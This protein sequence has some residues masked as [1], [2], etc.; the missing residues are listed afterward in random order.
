VFLYFL[1]FVFFVFVFAYLFIM[2]LINFLN[3]A[4]RNSV[5][6]KWASARTELVGKP[7][8]EEEREEEDLEVIEQ[9]K[10]VELE[11]WRTG[12]LKTGESDSNANFLPVAVDW[13]ERVERARR[14]AA[15]DKPS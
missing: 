15:K 14:I 10:R 9:K 3:R 4:K 1:F 2:I 13:R 8:K 11:Q 6:A 12:Q 7:Q 5:F